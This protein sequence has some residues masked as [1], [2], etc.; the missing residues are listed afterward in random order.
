MDD[1]NNNIYNENSQV[2]PIQMEADK[3]TRDENPDLKKSYESFDE[4]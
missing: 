4:D 1:R 2:M 3:S